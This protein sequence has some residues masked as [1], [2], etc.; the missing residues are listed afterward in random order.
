MFVRMNSS[1]ALD[2]TVSAIGEV[3]CIVLDTYGATEKGTETVYTISL[4]HTSYKR[5]CVMLS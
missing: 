3:V 5:T 4:E 2:R 1:H